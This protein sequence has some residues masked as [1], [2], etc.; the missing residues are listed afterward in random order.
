MH[1]FQY[2]SKIAIDA[3]EASIAKLRKTLQKCD[4]APVISEAISQLLEHTRK[5]YCDFRLQNVLATDEMKELTHK[6]M[7]QQ[8]S[9]GIT[10]F[11]RG[12]VSKYWA[13]IQNIYNK[14]KDFNDDKVC[15]TRSLIKAV[16]EYSVFV[17]TQRCEQVNGHSEKSI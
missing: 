15:W 8:L 12:Y 17:W 5:G 7:M 13:V 10:Y 11:L 16:W 1:I 4:T 2:Q 6:T 9:M 14:Q 3:H